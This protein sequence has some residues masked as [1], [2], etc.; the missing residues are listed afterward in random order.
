[1]SK[2]I[3]SYLVSGRGSNFRVIAENIIKGEINA[4]NGAVISNNKDA[5]ALDIARGLGIE[6]YYFDPAQFITREEYEKEIYKV[7]K[8]H[9]TDL[10]AAAGYMRIITPFLIKKFPNRIMNIH[11]A[12]LPSF[13]GKDAQKRAIEYGVKVSGCTVHFV[14]E[15]TDTGPIILQKAVSVLD[16]DTES[17]LSQRIIEEE[18]ILYSEAVK[19]FCEE[20]LVIRG[21]SVFIKKKHKF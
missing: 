16:D 2:K 10:I 1:M 11:P 6:T 19:L 8:I 3:V 4:M 20:R 9:S 15:G 21:R 14:D 7:M 5:P 12:L 13:P 17:T 18:H